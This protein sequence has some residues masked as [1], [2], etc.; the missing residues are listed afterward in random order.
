[1][2]R[3]RG[4]LFEKGQDAKSAAS[5]R[6]SGHADEVG[7]PIFVVGN[8]R[9]GTTMMGRALGR[10]PHVFTMGEIHF[11][12]QLRSAGGMDDRMPEA[13]AVRL[14]AR[15][16]CIQRDGYLRQG[17][18][19]RF[20]AEARE[21]LSR[22]PR[23]TPRRAHTAAEVFEGFLLHEAARGGKEVPC[24]HTPR[25][26]FYIGEILRLYPRARVIN[27]VRDPRDV[28]LS[29]KRKWKRRSLGAKGIPPRE[30]LRAWANYHPVTTSKLWN[31]SVRAA[32]RFAGHGRV[33]SL[34]FEDLLADP[35]GELRAVCEFI[36]ISF[37]DGLLEVPQVGSSSGRDRPDRKGIDPGRAGSWKKGGLGEAELFLCQRVTAPLMRRHGYFVEPVAPNPLRVAGSVLALGPKLALALAANLGRIKNLREALGRRLS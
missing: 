20:G 18:P 16:L 36:G 11:F 14:A 21:I 35:E 30:T 28:L 3:V 4:D 34:R 6:P 26:V 22:M 23:S 24:D 19:A 1:M 31:A 2:A 33:L 15:L 13:E 37:E 5:R 17:D 32:D 10:H 27:L 29:Q 25:N 12:E 8:S 7:C 9:S